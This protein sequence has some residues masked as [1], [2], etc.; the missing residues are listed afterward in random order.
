VSATAGQS[1]GGLSFLN[2]GS[3]R[4]GADGNLTQLTEGGE[5]AYETWTTA[6]SGANGV[7]NLYLQLAPMSEVEA[8]ANITVQV[9]YWATAGQGFTVQYSTPTN[10]YQNGPTVTSPGTGTWATATV[11]LTGA[12]LDELENGSADLRL[13]VTTPTAP[14]IVRSV[15]MSVTSNGPVLAASPSSLSFGNV[16]V[17]STSAAQTVTITNSGNAA[18]TVSGITAAA[19]FA[20][21]NTCGSSL[22]VGASCTASVTFAPTAGQTYSGDLT[23]NSNATNSPLLVALSGS[24]ATASTNLALDQPITASSVQQTYVAKNANDGNT[25]TYWEST[26]GTW[27][28]TLTVDLGSSQTLGST[29]LDLP[30]LT[31]WTTIVA[32]ATYTWNPSTGNTVTITFPSGTAYRY[33]RLNFT[34]NSVQNGAQVSEWQILG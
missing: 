24:G 28:S 10:K 26:N 3:T 25:S 21:T 14:L 11:Q 18:A 33:V 12:Q 4:T 27:P 34:A 17:G 1:G 9:T 32:S 19:G 23:V 6:Q 7:A 29:V 5:T 16:S 8:A 20:E 22:A 2:V 30:P 31:A 13:A 15:A